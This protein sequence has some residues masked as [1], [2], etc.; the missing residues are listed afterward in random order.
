MS[1]MIIGYLFTVFFLILLAYPYLRRLSPLRRLRLSLNYPLKA[2]L[3]SILVIGALVLVF[4]SWGLRSS[5]FAACR[6]CPLYTAG[7]GYSLSKIATQFPQLIFLY[8]AT[9]IPIFIVGCFVAGLIGRISWRLW[10]RNVFYSF[11]LAAVLP[12]CSCGVIPIVK[13]ML[14]RPHLSRKVVL[15]FLIATPILSPIV[16]ALSWGVLG[17]RYTLLRSTFTFLLAISSG[18]LISRLWKNSPQGRES[19]AEPKGVRFQNPVA[20]LPFPLGTWRYIVSLFRFIGLGLLLGS[21]FAVLL[22]SSFVK[23]F[24]Q[25]N[26]GG[27]L[28]MASVGIPIH[29]CSGAEVLILSPFVQMGLPLGHALAFTISG[30]GICISSIPLLL[31]VVGKRV[32]IWLLISFWVGSIL[33]GAITNLITPLIG[34]EMKFL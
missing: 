24:M 4:Y 1:Q 34:E 5:F 20:R 31:K 8:S 9:T 12:L 11:L 16:I 21:A 2:A 15:V 29:L 27:L 17:V 7:Q 10:P 22:P 23:M 30:A 6:S 25:N 13:A 14:E 19:L 3:T 18:F 32:T 28:A 26:L 33:I